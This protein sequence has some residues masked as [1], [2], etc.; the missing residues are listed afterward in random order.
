MSGLPW[1]RLDTQFATNPKVLD[2]VE[3][4]AW[5]AVAAYTFSLGY[6]GVHGTN[7]FIPRSALPFL[8]AT[9]REA[10]QLCEVRL[11]VPVEGGWDINGWTDFQPSTEE[12]AAR[13][14]RA[15]R[16]A[17]KRWAARRGH[18]EATS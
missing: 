8:H 3:D 9:R 10:T 6:A 2:L 16:A 14:E 12:H 7:G 4:K 13:S 17:Q 15:K 1:V 18:Q 5:R 11:W